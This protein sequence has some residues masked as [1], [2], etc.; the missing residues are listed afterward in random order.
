MTTTELDQ[1]RRDVTQWRRRAEAAEAR[2]D[3]AEQLI[4]DFVG[5]DPAGDLEFE[6][7]ASERL[8]A[9]LRTALTEEAS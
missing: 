9:D 2:I 7:N 4:V 3:A 5:Q 1:Y 8:C 6:S